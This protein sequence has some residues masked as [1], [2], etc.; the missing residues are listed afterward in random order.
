MPCAHI[1]GD[2]GLDGHRVDRETEEYG[3][4]GV[5]AD[6][7]SHPFRRLLL[8]NYSLIIWLVKINS[9]AVFESSLIYLALNASLSSFRKAEQRSSRWAGSYDLLVD[10]LG[11]IYIE[12][13]MLCI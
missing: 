10:N 13:T 3:L 4:V 5:L 12:G 9:S 8:L 7:M 2:L 1:P 6:L 11:G